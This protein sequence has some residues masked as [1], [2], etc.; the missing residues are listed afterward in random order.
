[1][2]IKFVAGFLT[3][4]AVMAAIFRAGYAPL[5][6]HGN[7][8]LVTFASSTTPA[9]LMTYTVRLDEDIHVLFAKAGCP[10]RA[11]EPRDALGERPEGEGR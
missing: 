9:D 6:L 3:G 2:N 10:C 7:S 8:D 5:W 4:C 11:T 1:M